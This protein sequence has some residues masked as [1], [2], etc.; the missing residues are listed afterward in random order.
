MTAV[1]VG[2][3][4]AKDIFDGARDGSKKLGAGEGSFLSENTGFS[5]G[6][7]QTA[8]GTC[9]VICP[10]ALYV[11]GDQGSAEAKEV[12]LSR[13]SQEFKCSQLLS[14]LTPDHTLQG[15]F[16]ES[17]RS[18]CRRGRFNQITGYFF[19]TVTT[20]QPSTRWREA[21]F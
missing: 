6:R 7:T 10:P 18:I 11:G 13:S 3:Q 17:F 14:A 4:V 21:F 20:R 5:S 9:H 12:S 15:R 1:W 2:W 19:L 16:L 8:L